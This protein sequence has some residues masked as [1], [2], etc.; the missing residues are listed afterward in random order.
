MLF[1]D[2]HDSTNDL[3]YNSN[4]YNTY[5][6]NG[7]SKKILN[8]KTNILFSYFTFLKI[9]LKK[10]YTWWHREIL[11]VFLYRDNSKKFIILFRSSFAIK[12]Q[13]I[14]EY[15]KPCFDKLHM[16]ASEPKWV[17]PDYILYKVNSLRLW[18][19]HIF[20][21]NPKT[22]FVFAGFTMQLYRE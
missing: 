22:F 10:V 8:V 11:Q 18:G 20:M 15:K 13:E 14:Q 4:Q 9:I 17:N 16:E 6:M 2:S 5:Q 19:F 3:S 7:F 21:K 12:D 1:L